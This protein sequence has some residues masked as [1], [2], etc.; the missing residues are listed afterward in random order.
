MTG[1]GL[2]RPERDPSDLGLLPA[3]TESAHYCD[4]GWLLR[5]LPGGPRPCS[6]CRPHLVRRVDPATGLE[7]WKVDRSKLPARRRTRRKR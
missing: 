1:G 6:R 5:D 2:P 4:D 7:G 3:A